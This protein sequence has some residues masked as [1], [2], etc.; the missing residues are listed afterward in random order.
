M[1]VLAV[2]VF[3]AIAVLVNLKKPKPPLFDRNLSLGAKVELASGKHV[4]YLDD[5]TRLELIQLL[6]GTRTLPV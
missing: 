1:L 2:V 3:I 5:Q 6:N 4:T